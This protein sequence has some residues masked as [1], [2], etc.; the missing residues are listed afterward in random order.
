MRLQQ[1]I[2]DA[3]QAMG[4]AS[5][6]LPVD[7]TQL[8]E[9]IVMSASPATVM[10]EAPEAAA[11]AGSSDASAE[12]TATPRDEELLELVADSLPSSD[13]ASETQATDA[14]SEETLELVFVDES[15]DGVEK[16]LADLR[17][18]SARDPERQLKIMLIDSESDGIAAISEALQQYDSVDAVHIVSH[19]TAGEVRL[20]STRLTT[21]S[22]DTYRD[23]IAGWQ[24]SLSDEADLLFYGCNLA[25]TENGQL[26]MQAIAAECDCD[27]SASEDLTGAAALGGDWDLEFETGEVETEVAFSESFQSNW[28]HSLADTDGDGVDDDV[29]IDDDN[30]GILDTVE[31]GYGLLRYEY[32]DS[33]PLNDTVDNIPTTGAL[34]TGTVSEIRPAFIQ[35]AVD[36]GDETHYSIRYTGFINIETAGSHTFST[37]S[38]DGSKLFIDGVEVVDN[39]LNVLAERDVDLHSDCEHRHIPSGDDMGCI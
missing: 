8:E 34:V 37:I 29:D 3:R 19:G 12:D 23:A 20:G 22:L 4:K 26:L 27:V 1:A 35:Q 38:N 31:L 17:A 18:E 24:R 39:G 5:N 16:I 11:A 13:E 21:D 15:V 9:R 25:A 7:V 32:Y 36:E 10:V 2:H 6:A 30:D 33:S 14:S 28:S